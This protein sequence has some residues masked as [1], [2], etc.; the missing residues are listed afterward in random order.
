MI[1]VYRWIDSWVVRLELLTMDCS[2][3]LFINHGLLTIIGSGLKLPGLREDCEDLRKRIEEGEVK[4]GRFIIV[5]V[6]AMTMSEQ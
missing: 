3:C 1:T 4:R 2:S 5:I 6:S